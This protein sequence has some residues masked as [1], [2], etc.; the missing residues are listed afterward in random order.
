MS[1]VDTEHSKVF[2]LTLPWGAPYLDCFDLR[3]HPQMLYLIITLHQISR[4]DEACLTHQL[5][6]IVEEVC[7]GNASVREGL[8]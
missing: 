2:D 8:E 4:L 1:G 6:Q 3:V 7:R 5:S